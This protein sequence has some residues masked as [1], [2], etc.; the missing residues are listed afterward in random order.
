MEGEKI[1]FITND[2]A[3]NINRDLCKNTLLDNLISYR[4]DQDNDT[5]QIR[6]CCHSRSLLPIIKYISGEPLDIQTISSDQ[7]TFDLFTKI[8]GINKDFAN[9]IFKN[10]LT[11]IKCSDLCHLDKL[12]SG[13]LDLVL[14]SDFREWMF[15]L[16]SGI[17]EFI[18][19]DL[20]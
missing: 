1:T 19:L 14:W 5:N 15:H 17:N 8:L 11:N 12:Y 18:P 4:K 2:L 6:I 9:R 10:R 20:Q 3:I 16:V 7:K 13:S